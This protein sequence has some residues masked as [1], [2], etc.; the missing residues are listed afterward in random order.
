MLPSLPSPL[1][2]TWVIGVCNVIIMSCIH[3]QE[4]KIMVIDA[5]MHNDTCV[6]WHLL[7]EHKCPD[8]QGVLIYLVSLYTKGLY[9]DYA[10]VLIFECPAACV[11]IANIN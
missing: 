10:G 3:T 8:Y 9:L 4:I 7:P 11:A 1:R 5:Q 2:C 6:I